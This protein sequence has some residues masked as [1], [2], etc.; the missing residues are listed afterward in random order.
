[1]GVKNV[2]KKILLNNKKREIIPIDH[3]VD[4]NKSLLGKTALII[5]GTGGIGEAI[6][7]TF[8]EAGA[9]VIITGRTVEKMNCLT[10]RMIEKSL[11]VKSIQFDIMNIKLLDN[12]LEEAA[13][14]FGKIDIM[15]YSAGV[16]TENVNFWNIDEL[17]YDRIMKINIK[18]AFFCGQKVGKYMRENNIKGHLLFI[19]SSRGSEPAW[20]PYGISKWSLDGFIKGLAQILAMDGIIVNGIAPGSTA[21]SMLGVEKGQS[22]YT[23]ENM[24]QRLILPNEVSNLAKYLVSSAGDMMMGEIVHISGGRGLFDIR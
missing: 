9:N 13:S 10:N 21:T 24:V 4:E 6:V 3:Y 7:E 11:N 17:E 23:N 8:A 20:T 1:M 19:S 12:M 16:H 14:L 2:I 22:I 18:G 5:G 15:V